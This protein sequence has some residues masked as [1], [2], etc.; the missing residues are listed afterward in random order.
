[1]RIYYLILGISLGLFSSQ[2]SY[3]MEFLYWLFGKSENKII[4]DHEREVLLEELFTEFMKDT[5]IVP[6]FRF[7]IFTGI[8]P[9][10]KAA[11]EGNVE[12]IYYLLDKTLV[13]PNQQD[14]KGRTALF[15]AIERENM[16]LLSALHNKPGSNSI[17]LHDILNIIECLEEVSDTTMC[18][19]MGHTYDEWRLKFAQTRPIEQG[20]YDEYAVAQL[21]CFGHAHYKYYE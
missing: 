3:G 14:K 16:L 20:S 1:M 17:Y 19:M 12:K 5:E 21:P 6:R 10:M 18:D 15:Y 11:Q 4:A 7:A 13:D 8:T 9:L 2:S